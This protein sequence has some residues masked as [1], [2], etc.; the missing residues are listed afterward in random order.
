MVGQN[1]PFWKH[2]HQLRLGAVTT[3][4]AS[5][6]LKKLAKL[7]SPGIK[8]TLMRHGAK[9]PL[10]GVKIE[11]LKK[12]QKTIKT[13]HA[14]ALELYDTGNSDAMYLAGLIADPSRMTR[15]N[16]QG[17]V[18][19]ASWAMISEYTVAGVAAESPYGFELAMK[20]IDSARDSTAASGWFILGNLAR[21]KPDAELPLKEYR[22]LLARVGKEIHKSPNEV[23]YAM[24]NFM[25]ACGGGI[26]SLTDEAMA[27][28]QKIGKV[29]VDMGDT[30]CKV[31]DAG[32]YIENVRKMGRLGKK[33]GSARC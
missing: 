22:G 2:F 30:A 27:T 5:E 14:L 29:T 11:D 6:I 16:L 18:E 23:R 17:W 12:I 19:K 24:N 4:T 25:I 28:A 33:R 21:L 9:E 20:W 1:N 3:M 31:P 26:V 10:F 13:D 8:K 15:E 7:G 32:T